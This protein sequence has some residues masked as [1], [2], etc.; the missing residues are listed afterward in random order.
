MKTKYDYYE[1]VLSIFIKKIPK[2][3]LKKYLDKYSYYIDGDKISQN[4][5]DYIG[6]HIK[7]EY[8]W[9]TNISILETANNIVENAIFNGNIKI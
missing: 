4:L 6:K 9:M 3:L 1:Q 5:T 8:N 2:K 7:K